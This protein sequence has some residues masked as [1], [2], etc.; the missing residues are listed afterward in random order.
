MNGG[1]ERRAKKTHKRESDVERRE[2]ERE[3]EKA[4]E[5][6]R[7]SRSRERVTFTKDRGRECDQYGPGQRGRQHG[8]RVDHL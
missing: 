3:T 7:E 5:R 2:G 1:G 6:E 4:S 8:A